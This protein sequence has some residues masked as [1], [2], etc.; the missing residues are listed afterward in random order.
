MRL[1]VVAWIQMMYGL[2]ALHFGDALGKG[3]PGTSWEKLRSF[4]GDFLKW[5]THVDPTTT[6]SYPWHNSDDEQFGAIQWYMIVIFI[7]F[8]K[9]PIQ[10][11]IDIN[12]LAGSNFDF[13]GSTTCSGA[14]VNWAARFGVEFLRGLPFFPIFKSRDKLMRMGWLKREKQDSHS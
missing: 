9:F 7:I 4:G 6:D 10:L 12:P 3:S 5:L 8:H 13:P 1:H 14:K 2:L 11:V